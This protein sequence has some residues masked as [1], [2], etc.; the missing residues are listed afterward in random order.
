MPSILKLGA[1]QVWRKTVCA[2]RVQVICKSDLHTWTIHENYLTW[3]GRFFFLDWIQKYVAKRQ[4]TWQS[5]RSNHSASDHMN[6][7]SGQVG[8]DTFASGLIRLSYHPDLFRNTSATSSFSIS[9]HLLRSDLVFVFVN[10]EHFLY[11]VLL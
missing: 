7:N 4:L 8:L 9:Q 6:A 2:I 11:F 5:V 3:P 10:F 1:G